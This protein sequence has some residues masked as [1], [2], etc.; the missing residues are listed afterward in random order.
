[1]LY[2]ILIRYLKKDWREKHPWGKIGVSVVKKMPAIAK[3]VF[4][5]GALTLVADYIKMHHIDWLV[6]NGGFVGFNI[7]AYELDKFKGK[8]T[9]RTFNAFSLSN[10]KEVGLSGFFCVKK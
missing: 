7:A 4:V 3:Y 9:V 8:K 2:Q 10:F 1:M 6:M 5:G